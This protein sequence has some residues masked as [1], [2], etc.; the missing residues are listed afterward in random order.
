[1]FCCNIIYFYEYLIKFIGI[2]CWICED[3]IRNKNFFFLLFVDGFF[4]G[5]M[6]EY[7]YFLFFLNLN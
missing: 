2:S 7:V 1:M 6:V 5:L 4:W 3:V